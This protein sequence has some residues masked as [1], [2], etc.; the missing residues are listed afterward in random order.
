[1][2]LHVHEWGTGDR[3]AL[4]VHGLFADA[5]GNWHRVGPALAER[6]FH[7]LAPELRGHGQSPRGLYTPQLWADD[8]VDSLPKGAQ[9]A[10]GH[11][12]GGMSLALAV[13]RLQPKAAIY[14]DPAWKM[15]AGLHTSMGAAWQAQVHWTAEQ[16]RTANPRWSERDLQAR[17]ASMQL[18]DPAC[19]QGLAPG[20]GHDHAPQAAA[21]PSLV[22]VA[23]P[24]PF[25]PPEDVA[26]LRARG[27]T[28]ETL[29]GATHGMFREDFGLFMAAFDSWL[30]A[31]GTL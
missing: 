12:L 29:P 17:V 7:V 19:I 24:S 25:L 3:V 10:I 2:R 4:L 8:L 31:Q 13:D 26:E 28:A 20:G 1:M 22:L 21:P 27:L 14:I 30:A 9:V 15:S 18:F 23:D 16:W 5:A 6:G 11:S